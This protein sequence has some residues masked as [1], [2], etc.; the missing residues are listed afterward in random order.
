M[1]I[2][3][4]LASM[5]AQTVAPAEAGPVASECAKPALVKR[6]GMSATELNGTMQRAQAYV[7]CMSAAIEAQ[8]KL[9]D[10]TFVKA[11]EAAERNNAMVT[12]VN[13]FIA[14]VKAYQESQGSK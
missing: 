1:S 7:S 9:A 5:A 12:Q 8:R 6:E 2:I 13:A 10:E 3:F 14:E 4:L 11:K